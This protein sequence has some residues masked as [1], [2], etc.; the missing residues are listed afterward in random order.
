L[1]EEF[2]ILGEKQSEGE[3][4]SEGEKVEKAKRRVK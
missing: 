1:P 2:L 3:G 4:S